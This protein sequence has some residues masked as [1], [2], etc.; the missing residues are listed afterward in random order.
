MDHDCRH[1]DALDIITPD[2]RRWGVIIE[3]EDCFV[4]NTL[5]SLWDICSL[6][7]YKVIAGNLSGMSRRRGA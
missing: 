1:A 2:F 5:C 6:G 4:S 3:L 7:A